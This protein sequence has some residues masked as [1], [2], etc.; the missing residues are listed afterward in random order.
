MNELNTRAAPNND[1]CSKSRIPGD[2][3]V[4][5]L[6]LQQRTAIERD[7]L[8]FPDCIIT[9]LSKSTTTLCRVSIRLKNEDLSLDNKQAVEQ[10]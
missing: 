3:L 2:A 6:P 5:L 1:S 10:V 4:T 7:P 9:H 8:N